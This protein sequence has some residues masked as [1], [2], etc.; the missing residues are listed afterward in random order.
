MGV[1]G[2]KECV[3]VVVMLQLFL[4]VHCV[5]HFDVGLRITQYYCS[6]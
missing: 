4:T 2:K 1:G 6:V 3:L 5:Y